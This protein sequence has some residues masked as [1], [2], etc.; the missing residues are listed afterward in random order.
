MSSP[1]AGAFLLEDGE[2]LAHAIQNGDWVEGG[3]A[4]FSGALDTAAAI[5]D[6][7]GSLIAA[8]LGWLIEHVEPLKGWFN[9]LTGDAGEVSGFAQTWA[10]VAT[11]MHE[12]G[13]L[14][15]R[16]LGDLDGMSGA[17]VDAY[18]AYAADT[19][20][21]LHAAGDWSQAVATGLEI[22]STLVKIVHDLVRDALSQVVGMAISCATELIVSVGTAAPV[23]IE[24][25][26][27]RVASLAARIGKTITRLLTSFTSFKALFN[28]LQELMGK[29][30]GL[31]DRMPPGKAGS[32]GRANQGGAPARSAGVVQTGAETRPRN[33]LDDGDDW[34]E[35]EYDKVRG[36]TDDV[37]RIFENMTGKTLPNGHVLTR[38]ELAQIKS[39]V[40]NDSH[41]MTDY[42]TGELGRRRYD[43]S[44]DM[45]EAWHRLINGTGTHVDRLLLQHELAESNYLRAHP[46]ATYLEAHMYA[47]SVADWFT[48]KEEAKRSHGD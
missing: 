36:R 40:F 43:A 5:S 4:A 11:R 47:Q 13:D 39:H 10:N 6:P 32:G 2:T 28:S 30:K 15:T 22:C 19:A 20:K 31:F 8:G 46:E 37:D 29:A 45:A 44:A 25:I 21:H 35:G 26:G 42:E 12:S 27:T 24:Q 38:E 17:T 41:L 3:M 16:R 1:F 14:Y 18:L 33:T 23:V 7:L 48:A 9:D 34:A